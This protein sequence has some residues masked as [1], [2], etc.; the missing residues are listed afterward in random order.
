[1]D[2]D[3]KTNRVMPMFGRLLAVTA[4]TFIGIDL[5]PESIKSALLG[6]WKKTAT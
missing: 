5:G 2:M 4:A 1:M 3:Q 6:S